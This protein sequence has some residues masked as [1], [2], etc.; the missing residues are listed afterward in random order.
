MRNS[1]NPWS[2][3]DKRES[4]E[5]PE[6]RLL[7]KGFADPDFSTRKASSILASKYYEYL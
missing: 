6:F 7:E 3:G 2:W 5:L 4:L 1:Y